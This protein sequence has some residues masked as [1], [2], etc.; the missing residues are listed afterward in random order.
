MIAIA[1][2]LIL[3]IL[4]LFVTR[5]GAVALTLTGMTR[6]AARFQARSALTG[7][8]FTTSESEQVVSHPVRR[9]IVG[10][11]MLLGNIGI[12]AASGTL[13]L[14]LIGIEGRAD[15]WRLAVLFAGLIVLYIIASSSVIDRVMCGMIAWVLCRYTDVETRDFVTLLHLKG[16]YQ[17][18]EIKVESNDWIAGKSIAEANLKNVGILVLGLIDNNT[19]EGIVRGIHRIE[20]GQTL[21][22]YG[23]PSAVAH[24]EGGRLHDIHHEGIEHD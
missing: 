8:G 17:I 24:L 20:M 1:S 3:V 14:S 23:I 21:I 4:S 2:L 12:V 5:I 10:I 16:D 22:V 15:A 19:Y 11:L 13:I 9:K 7:A 18:A 6:D